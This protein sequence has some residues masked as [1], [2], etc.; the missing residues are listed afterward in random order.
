MRAAPNCQHLDNYRCCRVHRPH[1]L[2]AA[3]FPKLRPGCILDRELPPRD[4]QWTC[5]DQT[6]LPRPAGPPPMP[7]KS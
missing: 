3:L 4:G 5:P 1:W 2:V 6:P 7:K